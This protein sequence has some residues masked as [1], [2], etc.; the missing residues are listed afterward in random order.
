MCTWRGESWN[1]RHVQSSHAITCTHITR[2]E[3]VS[4]FLKFSFVA[5]E[6]KLHTLVR[7]CLVVLLCVCAFIFL[8]LIEVSGFN[9][10]G[11]IW[12][13]GIRDTFIALF[14]L[15][16]SLFLACFSGTRNL[17][18]KSLK[19]RGRKKGLSFFLDCDAP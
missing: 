16:F 7:I 13:E 17:L 4:L 5:T 2:D 3:N 6:Y 1:L 19:K 14:L 8:P 11:F 10:G 9:G 12:E 15:P 18:F